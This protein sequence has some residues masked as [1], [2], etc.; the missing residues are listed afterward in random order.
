MKI[1][2]VNTIL[3]H[4]LNAFAYHKNSLHNR[5]FSIRNCNAYTLHITLVRSKNDIINYNKIIVPS[6]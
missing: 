3:E 6:R 1:M 5:F 2:I 4:G